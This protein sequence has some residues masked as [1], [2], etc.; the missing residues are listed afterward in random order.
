MYADLG[1]F[2]REINNQIISKK[3]IINTL[4]KLKMII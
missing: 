2:S 3:I 4:N 1:V